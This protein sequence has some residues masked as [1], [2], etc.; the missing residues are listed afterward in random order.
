[1]FLS[2]SFSHSVP[3]DIL[4]FLTGQEEIETAAEIL[5]LRTKGLG[6]RIRELMICPIYSTL[7]SDMQAKIFEQVQEG[8][9]KVVLGECDIC[10]PTGFNFYFYYYFI[11][12]CLA[13]CSHIYL[14]FVIPLLIHFKTF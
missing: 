9:R 13:V 3:G 5:N 12:N 14:Y 1:M 7:P 4:V 8:A 6:S 2:F 10:P 11:F